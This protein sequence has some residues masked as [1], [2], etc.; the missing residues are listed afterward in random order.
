MA[1]VREMLAEQNRASAKL[2]MEEVQ[3]RH[4]RDAELHRS[5]MEATSKSA[6]VA[7]KT[8]VV[9]NGGAAVAL[10]AF[11]GG[12]LGKEIVTVQQVAD[13]SSVLI[14]FAAGVACGVGA[15]AFIYLMNYVAAREI[16]TRLPE[17]HRMIWWPSLGRRFHR[18]TY[19]VAH[20]IAVVV[21]LTSLGLFVIG[22]L[23]V[24]AS[25]TRLGAPNK[26]ALTQPSAH[27]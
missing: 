6:E 21:S 13:V 15:L 4:G 11:I 16:R 9:V 18:T 23:E 27:P 19:A 8:S 7:V 25:I 1:S 10:L 20:T 12:M 14:W 3:G 5:L 2:E 22:M 26:P 24:R 17:F